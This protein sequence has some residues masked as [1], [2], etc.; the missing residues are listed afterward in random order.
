MHRA[1]QARSKRR[2]NFDNW[3][4]IRIPN[5]EEAKNKGMKTEGFGG[6]GSDWATLYQEKPKRW[7]PPNRPLTLE[8]M[9]IRKAVNAAADAALKADVPPEVIGM[10]AVRAEDVAKA[11]P[12]GV[13]K[14]AAAKGVMQGLINGAA[15]FQNEDGSYT[16]PHKAVERMAQGIQGD[17]E[18]SLNESV[19]RRLW[20]LQF[21][22]DSNIVHTLRRLGKEEVGW[23][24]V[25]MRE[26]F[27]Q[28]EDGYDAD[29]IPEQ[30]AVFT[31][32]GLDPHD[33]KTV[34]AVIDVVEG[35]A[36][37]ADPRINKAAAD[38][39]EFMERMR[40]FLANK[41]VS[42]TLDSGEKFP[43]KQILKKPHIAHFINYDAKLTDPDTGVT[44]TLRE[45]MGH[46][47]GELQRLRYMEAYARQIGKPV[48]EARV[49]IQELER[50]MKGPRLGQVKGERSINVP[51]YYK[52]FD[53][54]LRY[55]K[56]VSTAAAMEET[57]GGEM[58]KLKKEVGKVP[59]EK[60]RKDILYSFKTMFEVPDWNTAFGN[61]VKKGQGFEALTKMPLSALKV[62]FHLVHASMGLKGRG[63]PILKAGLE[64]IKNPREFM[65]EKYQLGVVGSRTENPWLLAGRYEKGLGKE[66]FK[67]T[68]FD[69]VYRWVRGITGESAKVYMEQNAL[70]DLRKGGSRAEESRRILKRNFLIGDNAIDEAIRTGQWSEEDLAKAQRAFANKVTFS[71]NPGQMP[72]LA[73]LSLANDSKTMNELAAGV[74]GTYAL[75]TFSIKTYSFLRDALYDEVVV[76]HNL[77]PLTPF[78][79]LYPV[80]GQLITGLTTGVKHGVNLASEQLRGKEHKRDSFDNWVQQ[81]KNLK[82]HP[83]TGALMLW[84]DG[85]CVA[86]AMERTKRVADIVLL[87]AEG[88][89]N[90]ADDMM[91]YWINDELEGDFG[92]IYTDMLYFAKAGVDEG[93]DLW[94]YASDHAKQLTATEKHIFGELEK[95]I[96]LTRDLPYVDDMK[97]QYIQPQ[98]RR[99]PSINDNE[100]EPPSSKRKNKWAAPT[101][102]DH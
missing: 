29:H 17:D 38:Q 73:R 3:S 76:H 1:I 51:F 92:S 26:D 81:F 87:M 28:K 75:Q 30:L 47:F 80:A 40:Q 6:K 48:E 98:P 59:N 11:A 62:P 44:K 12:E 102:W 72:S 68:G 7:E 69:M 56:Q 84:V 61:I 82:H 32:N 89:K 50:R 55:V 95:L 85:A 58:E 99:W 16:V 37:S 18:R 21:S 13:D 90:Q 79:L 65:R 4:G 46:S 43:Y 83:V 101:P 35:H 71:R 64:W 93:R 94:K 25:N 10:S 41:N 57:F 97:N 53:H 34:G 66:V 42:V 78:L 9:R 31:K 33:D 2:V 5:A 39:E 27:T 52:D 19:L 20:N 45:V 54:L 8:D 24:I 36:A 15:A 86:A 88:H 74:R 60:A 23:K 49:W 63:T 100:D 14:E 22:Q 96:P 67:D 91:K 77:K 70:G